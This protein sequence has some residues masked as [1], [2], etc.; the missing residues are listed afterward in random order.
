MEYYLIILYADIFRF[1]QN[2]VVSYG[3][4]V[5]CES[6]MSMILNLSFLIYSPLKLPSLL[7]LFDLA[8]NI[9]SGYFN[10]AI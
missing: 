6:D 7:I 8:E 1:E 3:F 10:V 2:S 5:T 9:A 4:G